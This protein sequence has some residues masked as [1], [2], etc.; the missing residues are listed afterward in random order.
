MDSDELDA[1]QLDRID[2]IEFIMINLTQ[3]SNKI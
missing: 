3:Y 1:Q 2:T